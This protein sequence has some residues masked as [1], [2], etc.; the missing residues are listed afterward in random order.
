M[1][2][3]DENGAPIR[4]GAILKTSDSRGKGGEAKGGEGA[5]YELPRDPS[6]VAKIY[7]P[8]KRLGKTE[9]V[10]HL[11]G[12]RSKTLHEVAAMP[13]S[14]LFESTDRQKACGF[15]MP[16]VKGK[17]IHHLYNPHDR[18]IHFPSADWDF[19]IHV[20]KNSAAAFETL[21]EHGGL[22]ADV[23]ERNLLVTENGYVR[24]I[25]CDSYQFSHGSKVFHCDV[26]V[27]LWTAPELQG[28][29]FRGLVRTKNHDRFGL[30][31]LL[32]QLL[33]MGRHPFAGVPD[34][35]EQFEIDEGIGKFLFAFTTKT[36]SLG[37]RPPPN[38][39][40]LSALP[41]N[42]SHLFERAFLRGSE[43]DSARPSGRDWFQGLDFLSKT[44]RG[45]SRD[46]RHKYPS[47]LAKCPWCELS[48]GGGPNFFQT[49]IIHVTPEFEA[50]DVSAYWAAIRQ[51][52]PR[53]LSAKDPAAFGIPKL[54]PTP[55]PT[56]MSK[57]RPGFYVGWL[58]IA[59]S[60][61]LFWV[62]GCLAATGILIGW[63]LVADGSVSGEYSG[64]ANRRFQAVEDAKAEVQKCVTD[65]KKA[66]ADYHQQFSKRKAEL[67]ANYDRY[68]R[69][70]QERQNELQKLEAMKR[71]LQL[72][73]FLDTILIRDYDIPGIKA[74][75]KQTL[76]AYGIETAFDVLNA[77]NVP[78][79]GPHLVSVLMNWR[80]Q[81]ETR[82]CFNPAG[83]LPPK[84]VH[85]LDLRMIELRRS[86]EIQLRGGS[87]SL[88]EI[89]IAAE[90]RLRECEAR[91]ETLIRK[92]AQAQADDSLCA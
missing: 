52:L 61:P 19:L 87:Q 44:L 57:T 46:P 17:E 86:L 56:G 82:F 65:A 66:V 49:V 29:D 73:A 25:D 55:M 69:L 40:S 62:V 8:D 16:M 18:Y 83:P 9:K 32:F 53:S 14:L 1:N 58:M 81:C 35:S 70:N 59:A 24:L 47:H 7:L 3:V 26:G 72:N 64:E 41:D 74:K 90:R 71:R 36:R 12:L 85:Q 21:H 68:L 67:Q 10:R 92:L 79:F 20:A 30:A 51:I 37:I 5:I 50:G 39:L 23:N 88:N 6:S 45:C 22:M 31:V 75:R 13:T 28:R 11:L 48:D 60:V 91:L 42:L 4:L 38:V 77:K 33:F 63:W 54:Q 78:G 2:L 34:R 80:L 27:P 76:Q 89:G 15:I 84:E 43:R